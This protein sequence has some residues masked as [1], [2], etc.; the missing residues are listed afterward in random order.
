MVGSPSVET[1][2][3]LYADRTGGIYLVQ[4]TTTANPNGATADSAW[5]TI[6]TILVDA[7]IPS[8][9][10]RHV[11]EFT[12]INATGIRLRTPDGA[13]IDE[14]EVYAPEPADVAWGAALTI[15]DIIP[16]PAASPLRISEIAGTNAT[17]WKIELQNTGATPMEIGGIVLTYSGAP[18]GGYTI[19]AQTLAAGAF[20]SLDQTVLGFRPQPDDRIFL[21]STGRTG[22]IGRPSSESHHAGA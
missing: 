17:T 6:G 8:P 4:Y 2:R 5:T 15:R 10:L 21:L 20:L 13:C 14:L 19:P 3:E 11:Y 16:D 1:T 7:S 18:N 12:P 9:S 22:L